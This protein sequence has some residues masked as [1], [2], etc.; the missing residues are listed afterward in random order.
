[1][2]LLLLATCLGMELLWGWVYSLQLLPDPEV[3]D[4]K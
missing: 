4:D 3:C 1:M 2:F